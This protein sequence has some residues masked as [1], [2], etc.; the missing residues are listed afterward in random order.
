MTH[1]IASGDVEN[2]LATLYGLVLANLLFA[3]LAKIVE[4]AAQAEEA[5]RQA[6]IDWLAA[7]LAEAMPP[8]RAAPAAAQAA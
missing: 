8:R 3:P 4:R 6:V 7:Q 1:C 2:P 5:E